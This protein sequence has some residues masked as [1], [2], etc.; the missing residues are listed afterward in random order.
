MGPLASLNWSGRDRI[1]D[2]AR[3]GDRRIITTNEDTR[4]GVPF[5]WGNTTSNDGDG[6]ADSQK[7]AL[8][9]NCNPCTSD[10]N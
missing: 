6:I 9:G 1:D 10:V 5:L 7:R 3:T 4:S 8:S 2:Q